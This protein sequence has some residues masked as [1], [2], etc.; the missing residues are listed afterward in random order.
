MILQMERIINSNIF[1]RFSTEKEMHLKSN[2]RWKKRTI[3]QTTKLSRVNLI[4]SLGCLVAFILISFYPLINYI[5]NSTYITQ[6][7]AFLEELS[8]VH[9]ARG[10]TAF[11]KS[12]AYTRI[13]S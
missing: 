12:L 2:I 1:M 9:T 8:Y 11:A 10:H 13:Y 5:I 3:A 4:A 7:K 6:L